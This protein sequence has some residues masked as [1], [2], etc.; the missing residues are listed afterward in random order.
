MKHQSNHP[1]GPRTPFL[2]P[3][4][5][6]ALL[7]ISI[8]L[9]DPHAFA[10][11]LR[12]SNAGQEENP[13]RSRLQAEL[14]AGLEE[15]VPEL[16]VKNLQQIGKGRWKILLDFLK[17]NETWIAVLSERS[18]VSEAITTILWKEWISQPSLKGNYRPADR[19]PFISHVVEALRQAHIAAG[20]KESW[21]V[22]V[23]A[24]QVVVK[25]TAL[26]EQIPGYGK[27]ISIPSPKER[28]PKPTPRLLQAIEALETVLVQNFLSG[29][30]SIDITKI[31]QF[32]KEKI[33]PTYKSNGQNIL[34]DDRFQL[35]VGGL[36]RLYMHQVGR[37]LFL[38]TAGNDR[39]WGLYR[40]G[41]ERNWDKIPYLA[42][43]FIYINEGRIEGSL[44]P[45]LGGSSNG[46]WAILNPEWQDQQEQELLD[47]LRKGTPFFQLGGVYQ[48]TELA[49]R[50]FG[51]RAKARLEEIAHAKDF[52]WA[53]LYHGISSLLVQHDSNL[54]MAEALVRPDSD[55]D[56][57]VWALAK[58]FSTRQEQ[59]N[60][61]S[62]IVEMSG[63][64]ASLSEHMKMLLDQG[65][66][67]Q[68]FL[69]FAEHLMH[70]ITSFSQFL[71][72]ADTGAAKIYL[73]AFDGSEVQFIEDILPYF[74]KQPSPGRAAFE[75]V[76][77]F[78]RSNFWTL[79]DRIALLNGDT[80][81]EVLSRSAGLEEDRITDELRTDEAIQPANRARGELILRRRFK[82]AATTGEA[83]KQYGP[84]ESAVIKPRLGNILSSAALQGLTEAVVNL[85][86]HGGGGDL[87]IFLAL[88]DAEGVSRV[89]IRLADKGPGVTDPRELLER[90]M[91]VHAGIQTNPHEEPRGYGWKNIADPAVEMTVESGRVKW[92]LIREGSNLRFGWE[93][94][95]EAD[96]GTVVTVVYESKP[97]AG[98]EE[99]GTDDESTVKRW[100]HVPTDP[101]DAVSRLVDALIA[102]E[103][104]G[105]QKLTF[106]RTSVLLD[107]SPTQQT[108]SL[109]PALVAEMNRLLKVVV[110]KAEPRRVLLRPVW[111]KFHAS[112]LTAVIIQKGAVPVR[113]DPVEAVGRLVDAMITK[114]YGADRR[115]SLKQT[116]V[117][118][119]GV[120]SQS[121]L[122]RNQGLVERMNELLVIVAA[123][124][125]PSEPRLIPVW[126]R[127]HQ[128][129]LKS[130]VVA[131]EIRSAAPVFAGQEERQVLR[132][133][134]DQ[135]GAKMVA[136]QGAAWTP[137]SPATPQ[138]LILPNDPGWALTIDE[139]ELRQLAEFLLQ[140]FQDNIAHDY[141]L[142]MT[143]QKIIEAI[144]NV[145][146]VPG[147]EPYYGMLTRN[148]F[149]GLIDM[150]EEDLFLPAGSSLQL[151]ALG[152]IAA[153]STLDLP[154]QEVPYLGGRASTWIVSMKLQI[155]QR[156][157]GSFIYGSSLKNLSF[158]D[159]E[160]ARQSMEFQYQEFLS[161]GKARGIPPAALELVQQLHDSDP[162]EYQQLFG[163]ESAKREEISHARDFV[164]AAYFYQ[165][166]LDFK[167]VVHPFVAEA[168]IRPNSFLDR[169]V[170]NP[171]KRGAADIVIA[172]R[173]IV[174]L[175]GQTQGLAETL[176]ALRDSKGED[177]AY[178]YFWLYLFQKTEERLHQ[179]GTVSAGHAQSAAELVFD[180]LKEEGFTDLQ[181]LEAH[182]RAVP[183]THG[184]S[185]VEVAERLHDGNFLTEPDRIAILERSDRGEQVSLGVRQTAAG[186]EENTVQSITA[187]E[188]RTRFSDIPVQDG[189]TGYLVPAAALTQV[190]LYA[191]GSVSIMLGGMIKSQSNLLPNVQIKLKNIPAAPAGLQAPGVVVWDR[192]L[193]RPYE[194]TLL[195]EMELDMVDPAPDLLALVLM[196]LRGPGAEL[197]TGISLYTIKEAQTNNE[198]YLFV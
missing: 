88:P 126:E 33:D 105:E 191:P 102:Q 158:Y 155:D 183:N 198:Y 64:L 66:D 41:G 87:E 149:M 192:A 140:Q 38:R 45:N 167:G 195:P 20:P 106:D 26:S 144:R 48:E 193:N 171:A 58:E 84:Y 132:F 152:R 37:H 136:E 145:Y 73:R 52:I 107:R 7:I 190:N 13:T 54:L 186:Q 85:I 178:A 75:W 131:K 44:A 81:A 100:T 118:L 157:P 146:P 51:H 12:V 53:S 154:W 78:Y 156:A 35:Y 116:A 148:N 60:T 6:S 170:W 130:V 19:Q 10:D 138:R 181:Q 27:Q 160:V 196:A 67:Q 43:Q 55:L 189:E 185:A 68:A 172:S 177:W 15:G 16:A 91:D 96:E 62:A 110:G 69:V 50:V 59:K 8:A 134:P 3:R 164:W 182:L 175:S 93:G 90:S 101:V 194:Q 34:S 97:A 187:D 2:F 117:L 169:T 22:R 28:I 127:F 40:F 71:N 128:S 31:E 32:I 21:I 151:A 11:T 9:T 83:L 184:S 176:K 147:L 99:N 150:L 14:S 65:K 89:T 86:E 159:P 168:A 165:L 104:K 18:R 79:E 80:I 137:L 129:R 123:D 29:A 17:Q 115:L 49:Q 46:G 4:F 180:F 39:L 103:A 94:P 161:R 135:G 76:D 174:E 47:M 111:A 179:A 119:N 98:Q 163:V 23:D 162:A 109:N 74:K 92:Q 77:K 173:D 133:Y 197:K 72:I 188:I 143:D 124:E 153:Y 36:N 125:R 108:L 121:A 114:R 5:L 70:Q 141:P 30:S 61:A 82:A 120:P 113:T 63:D 1:V 57:E 95:T 56:R 25:K 166:I 142:Q 24:G 122:S 42:G 112:E 139:A